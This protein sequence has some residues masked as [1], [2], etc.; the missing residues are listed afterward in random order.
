MNRLIESVTVTSESKDGTKKCLCGHCDNSIIKDEEVDEK[1]C[2][3]VKEFQ[4]PI[5]NGYSK[6]IG[7]KSDYENKMNKI[8]D[9]LEDNE[10][11]LQLE[12]DFND[13]VF[14]FDTEQYKDYNCKINAN[15][16][17]LNFPGTHDWYWFISVPDEDLKTFQD[18][19]SE[20]PIYFVNFEIPEIK[21]EAKNMKEFLSQWFPENKLGFLSNKHIKQY[22]PII[23]NEEDEFIDNTN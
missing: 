19:I 6:L 12:T 4:K 10:E 20:Y 3:I 22:I 2:K 1:W 21:L 9:F 11:Y 17:Q 18:N 16:F 14:K 15:M 23:I 13:I 7:Q 8:K 5:G